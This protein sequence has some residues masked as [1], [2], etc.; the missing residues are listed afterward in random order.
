MLQNKYKVLII[1]HEASLT[2]A[3]LFLTNLLRFLKINSTQNEYMIF[4]SKNGELIETLRREKF[5]VFVCDKRTESTSHSK[6]FIRRIIYYLSFIKFLL[7]CRPNLIYSNTIVN[8]GEVIL[9]KIFRIPVILHMHEG[10]NFSSSC[11]FRLRIASYLTD[12]IIVGSCYVNFVLNKLTNRNGIVVYNGIDFSSQ[13]A[14]LDRFYD[15]ILKLGILGTI[16]NNKGHLVALEAMRLLI[17]NG[18][19]VQLQIAGKVC[20]DIYFA[21]LCKFIKF[22]HLDRHVQFLGMVSNSYNFVQSIDMLIVCSFDE[23]FPT[24]ILEAFAAGTLVVA[25]DVG[26]IPEIVDDRINGF[27]FK[28]GDYKMLANILQNIALNFSA[29]RNLT[30]AALNKLY[31]KFSSQNNYGV[32]LNLINKMLS[33]YNFV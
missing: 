20:D 31:Q 19:N 25:S 9:S 24:V 2:G 5:D 10:M 18:F 7:K 33:S 23:A 32:I 12:R 14:K 28:A 27:L 15:G 26:G 6:I 8:F 3:P 22:N 1:S 21:N 4:F 17:Q 13:S 30:S 29:T 16:N 11:R